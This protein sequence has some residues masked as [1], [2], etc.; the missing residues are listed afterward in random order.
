MAKL[1]IPSPHFLSYIV[2]LA[3]VTEDMLWRI[4]KRE[5][6]WGGMH[7]DSLRVSAEYEALWQL[8]HSM[9]DLLTHLV[10]VGWN[11]ALQF[12]QP[13]QILLF[14]ISEY[15]PCMHSSLVEG[16]F[17]RSPLASGLG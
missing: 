7:F 12:L 4:C 5:V 1:E 3:L 16:C 17:Y 15:L 14:G 2:Q 11:M 9:A 10:G 13:G 8:S 6:E